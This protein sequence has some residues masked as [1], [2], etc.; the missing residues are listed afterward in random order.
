CK[1]VRAK[2]PKN[3]GGHGRRNA[4][5]GRTAWSPPGTDKTDMDFWLTLPEIR[6]QSCLSPGSEPTP[7][8]GFSPRFPLSPGFFCP[9]V[10]VPGFLTRRFAWH[11]DGVDQDDLG[12]ALALGADGFDQ[13]VGGLLADGGAALVDGR[14]R[15]AQQVGVVDVAGADDF[16]LPRNG[17]AGFKDGFHG[18]GGG[19]VIVAEDGIG[20]G[21]YRE[22]AAC[23][24]ITAGI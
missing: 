14:E 13:H 23:R 5:V 6:C 3:S 21:L 4:A 16:D 24:E 17:D 8:G 22:Q 12:G 7:R 19:G 2:G 1:A 18:A 11:Q 10:S 9:R 15:H 20:T